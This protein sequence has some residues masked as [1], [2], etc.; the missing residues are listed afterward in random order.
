MNK[1]KFS[2]YKEYPKTCSQDDFWGQV[3][4]TVNGVPVANDQIEMIVEAVT[5]GLKLSPKDK[6][7]DLCCGNG[8]LSDLLFKK[9]M[10]GVGVDF[11]EYLISI[12]NRY[13]A[14][15]DNDRRYILNDV[16][17]F[18][19]H[20]TS[21]DTFSK[22][23]CYGSFAYIEHERAEKLLIALKENFMNLKCVYIGN[24]PDK[25][26][27]VEFTENHEFIHGSDN[28]PDT[29]IGIWRTKEEFKSFAQSC[30]WCISFHEMPDTFYASHYR[31]DAIL[32]NEY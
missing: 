14:D 18:C 29:P 26:L 6:L 31:Y 7:I 8:A 5:T 27:L 1:D 20:P 28:N 23:V 15:Q 32:F 9:C 19:E 22:A 17:D 3:K 30:G 4:R 25:D 21:P 16:V 24:C 10:G 13:F 2:F 12:A 11:S